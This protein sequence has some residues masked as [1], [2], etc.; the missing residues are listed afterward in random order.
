[1]TRCRENLQ[2]GN[3]SAD[4]EENFCIL[5]DG[6]LVDV[7]GLPAQNPEFRISAKDIF[8]HGFD[9]CVHMISAG[10]HR[11]ISDVDNLFEMFR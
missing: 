1:M 11:K 4:R 10:L 2:L 8:A 5:I 6:T 9:V 7:F 3:H